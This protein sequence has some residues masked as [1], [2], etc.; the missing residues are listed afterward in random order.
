MGQLDGWFKSWVPD[1]VFSAGGGRGS[2]EA[3]YTSALDIE[4]VL[5]GATDSDVHLFVADVTKSFDTVD[6]GIL[7]RGFELSRFARLVPPCLLMR[8]KLASGLGEPWTRDG[9]IPQGC[10]L[11]MMF[12]VALYLPW[13]CSVVC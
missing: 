4:E 5:T 13:C 10:P 12:I 3:W 2:V 8:F 11:S 7:D 9:G 6:R 1:S